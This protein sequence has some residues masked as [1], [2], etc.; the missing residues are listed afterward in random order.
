MKWEKF[1]HWKERQ[2]DMF[3]WWRGMSIGEMERSLSDTFGESMTGPD[4]I[5]IHLYGEWPNE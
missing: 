3:I 5:R 2:Y 1:G 4:T